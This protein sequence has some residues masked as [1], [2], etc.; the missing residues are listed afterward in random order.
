[1]EGDG[2]NRPAAWALLKP[3]RGAPYGFWYG[4]LRQ[5]I[6]YAQ[7]VAQ[8]FENAEIRVYKRDGTLQ[9]RQVRRGLALVSK[10]RRSA[11]EINRD[12]ER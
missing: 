5:A 1:M 9:E 6:S 4:E 11:L 8:D 7:W 2:G 3:C 12:E 10:R